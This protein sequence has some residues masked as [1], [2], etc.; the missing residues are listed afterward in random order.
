[1]AKDEIPDVGDVIEQLQELKQLIVGVETQM[2]T[3]FDRIKDVIISYLT[4]GNEFNLGS[5]KTALKNI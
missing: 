1:M 4:L 5:L 3:R 2:N